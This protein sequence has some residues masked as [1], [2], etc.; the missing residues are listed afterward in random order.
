MAEQRSQVPD[1]FE[2]V[3]NG[4]ARLVIDGEVWRLRRP[5]LGEYRKLRE[6]LDARDDDHLR[7]VASVPSVD[8]APEDATAEEKVDYTIA[9]RRRSRALGDEVTALNVRWLS[10]ALTLLADRPPPPADDWPSG[11]DETETISALVKHWRSVP[12]RS[13]GS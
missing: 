3:P 8:R 11:M 4:T 13:G 12:L 7:L 9:V 1:G 10:E 6:L 2:L 5:K